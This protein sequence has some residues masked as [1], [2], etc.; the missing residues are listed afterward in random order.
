MPPWP[1][2]AQPAPPRP[3]TAAASQR[4]AAV[5]TRRCLCRCRC[6]RTDLKVWQSLGFSTQFV[7][8]L[9]LQSTFW[10]KMCYLGVGMLV[11]VAALLYADV[12]VAPRR[13]RTLLASAESSLNA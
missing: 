13:A 5:I 11:S 9:V 1:V 12:V 7:L 4:V 8:G 10:V 6:R 3:A 2:R